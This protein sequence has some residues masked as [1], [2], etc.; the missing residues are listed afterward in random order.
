MFPRAMRSGS[1]GGTAIRLD[2]SLL[3]F[4]LLIVW[5]FTIRFEPAHGRGVALAM[6]LV[7][8]VAFFASILAH[9]LAH[10]LEATHRGMEVEGITLFLFGGVT[11][12]HAHGQTPRDELAVAAV[13]PWISLVCGA[14]FGLVATFA[15]QLLPGALAGPVA[16][17]AGLLGW[18]NV[19][20]AAFNLVPGAPLDGGRVLRAILWMTLG[21]RDRA[22]TIA[23]RAG[24]LLGVAL[25]G[26]AVWLYLQQP[27]AFVGALMSALIGAFLFNAARSELVQARLDR[28]LTERTVAQLIDDLE[29]WSPTAPGDDTMA[30]PAPGVELDADLHELIDRFQGD[31]D[32]V[33]LERDGQH[34]GTLTQREAAR[35]IAA[36][37]AASRSRTSRRRP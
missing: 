3:L 18:L 10:A 8:T 1:I 26:F 20:L 15:D 32:V 2:P 37:K 16:E 17:V 24:Q 30:P 23:A 36:L 31:H 13:G 29:H 6:A 35:A 9:E 4:A 14:L 27:R 19:A 34:V 25:I 12:M 5:T 11:E 22:L 33:H 7:G 28:L 21:D